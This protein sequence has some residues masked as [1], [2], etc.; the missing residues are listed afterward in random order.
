MNDI[1][2][3]KSIAQTI[4]TKFELSLESIEKFDIEL[5]ELT[6]VAGNERAKETIEL[7][8]D[9]VKGFVSAL[10]Q[11]IE[12]IQSVSSDFESLDQ[13]LGDNFTSE[14]M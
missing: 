3:N 5:S 10:K 13:N 1:L 12:K 6:T 11:D 4:A 9:I 7:E 8:K 2:N 14:M